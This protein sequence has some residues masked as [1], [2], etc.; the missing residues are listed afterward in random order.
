MALPGGTRLEDVLGPSAELV[1]HHAH[2]VVTDVERTSMR[3]EGVE[4]HASSGG[5]AALLAATALKAGP[6]ALAVRLLAGCATGHAWTSD[7]RLGAARRVLN[8]KILRSGGASGGPVGGPGEE[9]EAAAEE[10]EEEAE[11]AEEEEAEE[12][13]EEEEDEDDDG[14]CRAHLAAK[15]ERVLALL[16]AVHV[17]TACEGGEPI[18]RQMEALV[19]RGDRHSSTSSRTPR[20]SP[21]SAATGAACAPSRSRR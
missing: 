9:A 12:E 14:T 19:V 7:E 6:Y 8:R 4:E 10:A 18:R 21:A 1:R 3:A 16:A 20:V 5:G 2:T 17:L 15:L 13:E 11:E